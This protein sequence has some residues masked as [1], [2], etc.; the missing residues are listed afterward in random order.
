M[1]SK[2][3]IISKIYYDEA[4]YGSIKQTYTEAKQKD[5]SITLDDVKKWM[6]KALEQKKQLRGYNSFV[7]QRP[8]QEYQMDLFFISKK[9]FPNEE[10]IGGLL[11]VDIFTKFI[12]IVPI[13]TKK[14]PEIL[15]AIKTIINKMGKPESM[16]TDNEGAWSAGTEIDKYFKANKIN[17]LITL[18]HAAF[19]ERSIRTIKDEIYKRAKPPSDT[20]W[21]SLLFQILLK[22]NHKQVHT[23]TGYTPADAEKAT[24][25][26]NVKL[27]I[28]MKTNKTRVYPDIEIGDY[29]R[30]HKS[31]D[32]LDKEHISTWSDKRYKVNEITEKFNQKLYFLECYTQN[33][34]KT[35]L[36]RHDIIL[37]A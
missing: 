2:D 21:S 6:H 33:N 15:E 36:L 3:E 7:A 1:S 5:K 19:A 23:T 11:I 37:T 17:H 16:Y 8:K 29:V 18:S 9:D 32:K 13:K 28:E 22:Y 10:Y 26:L 30:I 34:R 4:G 31:K 12:N 14:I 35:G 20:N 24:N 27:N 25:H